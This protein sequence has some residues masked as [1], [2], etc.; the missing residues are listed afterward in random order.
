MCKHFYFLDKIFNFSLNVKEG[1]VRCLEGPTLFLCKSF[2]V[3]DSVK[4]KSPRYK[5]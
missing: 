2:V 5:C 4:M 3:F 1:K